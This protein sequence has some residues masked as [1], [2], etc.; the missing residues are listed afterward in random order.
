MRLVPFFVQASFGIFFELL[1][2]T[3]YDLRFEGRENIKE[4]EL[5]F[6]YVCNHKSWIDHFIIIAGSLRRRGIV[7]IHLLVHD[8]VWEIPVIG[9]VTWLLGAY[10]ANKGKGIEVSLA[11]L[12]RDLARGEC[13]GIYPEGGCVREKDV[14]GEPKV[15]AAY[16]AYHTGREIIP[17]AIKGLEN[18]SVRGL[19]FG[20]RKVILKFGKPFKIDTATV[21]GNSPEETIELGRQFT[22]SKII[23]LYHSSLEPNPDGL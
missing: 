16:L 5:P 13:V 15:G 7:P 12:K 22:M 11:P 14:F 2:K 23:E 19:L 10:P 3:F 1:G 4:A 8:K 17:M 18:L 6:I 9:H 20:R 21:G